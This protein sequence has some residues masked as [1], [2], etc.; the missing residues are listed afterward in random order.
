MKAAP[1]DAALA[2][3]ADPHQRRAVELLSER[4]R[5]AGELAEALGLSGPAM[6]RRLKTLKE[7][8][9]VEEAHPDF[10]ARVRIYAL[11]QEGLAAM[12][13][14]LEAT[15]AMWTRQLSA[16]KAHLEDKA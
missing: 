2:A 9:L 16:F 13:A 7:S 4:P 14:W 5:R 15:E 6:S 10:D 11:K 1:V 8:G 3:L 12:K